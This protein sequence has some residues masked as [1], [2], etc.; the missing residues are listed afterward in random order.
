MLPEW[1]MTAM[2]PL[3]PTLLGYGLRKQSKMGLVACIQQTFIWCSYYWNVFIPDPAFLWNILAQWT[4]KS[5]L[6]GWSCFHSAFSFFLFSKKDMSLLYNEGLLRKFQFVRQLFCWQCKFYIVGPIF[7]RKKS[8]SESFLA[9]LPLKIIV[10]VYSLCL[11]KLPC[12][13]LW[14]LQYF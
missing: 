1:P 10:A 13:L 14:R 4:R 8:A 5:Y 2:L 11:W 9:C 3:L 12:D 6:V 7:K